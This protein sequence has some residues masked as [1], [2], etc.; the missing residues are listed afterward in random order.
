MYFHRTERCPT[1]KMLGGYSAE[2]VK[3]GFA[4]QMTEGSV[5]FRMI[6]FEKKENAGLVKAYKVTGPALILAKITDNNVEK[7][8][9]MDQ[10]WTKVR[11]K[12]KFIEYVQTGVK[13]YLK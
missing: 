2:A 10:I 6:D 9:D 5:E 11:E 7:Y 4:K 12:P 3:K 13:A 8:Q 1:C